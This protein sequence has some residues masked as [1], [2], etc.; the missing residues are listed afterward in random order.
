MSIAVMVLP[1]KKPVILPLR[2]ERR[3]HQRVRVDLQLQHPDL[4]EDNVTGS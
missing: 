4:V 2:D 3:P 1:R